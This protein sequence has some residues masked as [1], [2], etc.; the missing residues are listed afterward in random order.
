MIQ[1]HILGFIM[2][3]WL[4]EWYAIIE[5]LLWVTILAS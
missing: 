1:M 3:V 2:M 4:L 5:N